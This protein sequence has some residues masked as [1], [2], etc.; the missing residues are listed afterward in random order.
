MKEHFTQVIV[1]LTRAQ[2]SQL[3]PIYDEK[4]KIGD[5]SAIVAQ[6]WKDGMRVVV[7]TPK[8]VAKWQKAIGNTG[9]YKDAAFEPA[10]KIGE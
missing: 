10:Y 7:L 5:A 1:K 3:K 9:I 2:R 8:Q 6:V 4:D